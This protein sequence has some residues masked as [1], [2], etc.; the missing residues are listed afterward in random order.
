MLKNPNEDAYPSVVLRKGDLRVRV[1]LRDS[2]R[3]I[4]RAVRFD[5][6]GFVARVTYRGHQWFGPWHATDDPHRNDNVMG[7]AGEFGMGTEGMPPPLGFEQAA[8]GE[9]FVKIGVGVLRKQGERYRFGGHYE[10]IHDPEWQVEQRADAMEFSQECRSQDTW[11]YRYQKKIQLDESL[12]GFR[13]EY[14]LTNLGS[15]AIEQTYYSHNFI[16]IDDQPIGPQY[17]ITFGQPMTAENANPAARVTANRMFFNRPVNPGESFLIRF[18]A[19]PYAASANRVTVWN[20]S[21]GAG[22]RI[23]GDA[24]LSRFHVWTTDRVVCPEPFVA[25]RLRPGETFQW[26]DQY[27]LLVTAER[28]KP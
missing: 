15:R 23:T 5:R 1:Y 7:T 26:T 17:Q 24:G 9:P 12:P 4:N 2:E 8:P 25:I 6:S 3:G 19:G 21:T 27:E 18:S 11:S 28:E 10:L 22:I 20:Q 14:R 16:S 13:I